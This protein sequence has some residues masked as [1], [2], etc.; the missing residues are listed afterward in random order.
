CAWS[1]SRTSTRRRRRS[2]SASRTRSPAATDITP[3]SCSTSTTPCSCPNVG[4]ACARR[5]APPSE[6]A[7][8]GGYARVGQLLLRRRAIRDLAAHALLRALPLRHVSQGTRSAVRDLVRRAVCAAPGDRRRGPARPAEVVGSREADV[9]PRVRQPAL[10]RVD[11]PPR[12]HRHHAREH[13]GADR[14]E[15]RG[16]LV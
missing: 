11:E 2:R 14:P 1:A 7:H 9:L 12:L 3:T 13:G 6:E 5:S 15:A 8:H 4:A 16:A 10:L